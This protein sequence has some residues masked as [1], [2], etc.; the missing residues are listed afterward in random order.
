MTTGSS[1]SAPGGTAATGPNAKGDVA[2]DAEDKAV[3]RKIKSI[4]KGC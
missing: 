1:G 2:T 4:C 3:D